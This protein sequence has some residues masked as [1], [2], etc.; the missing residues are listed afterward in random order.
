[1]FSVLF[2]IQ[3][4]SLAYTG[5]L[6]HRIAFGFHPAPTAWLG[7]F[8]VLYATILY[9]LIGMVAGHSYPELPM[10]GV[11]PCPVTIFTFG[12]LLLTLRP[13]PVSLL[14]IPALWSLIG[15]SA[16]ILLSVRRI[17]FFLSAEWSAWDLSLRALVR[18]PDVGA[19]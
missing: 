3:A 16:A 18:R 19:V 7:A 10:F 13:P 11:T 6:Q 12:M 1:M 4:A 14:A 9:P 17:S 2:I 5:F 8:F 15:G